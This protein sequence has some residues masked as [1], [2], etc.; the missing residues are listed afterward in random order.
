MT[1]KSKSRTT[2]SVAKLS[3]PGPTLSDWRENWDL[4]PITPLPSVKP[5]QPGEY[6]HVGFCGR[7]LQSIEAIQPGGHSPRHQEDHT[8]L[9]STTK[10]A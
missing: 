3:P 5:F 6:M 1:R 7:C 8:P 9:C 4:F 2:K 10:K